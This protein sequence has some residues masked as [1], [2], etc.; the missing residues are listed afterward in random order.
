MQSRVSVRV[1]GH[2]LVECSH[3]FST[4]TPL[5]CTLS[6]WSDRSCT[7][8]TSYLGHRWL[9]HI[10]LLGEDTDQGSDPPAGDK[11]LSFIS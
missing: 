2:S 9:I 7:P 1:A 6:C 8:H 11:S 5:C 10:F 4:A 3:V